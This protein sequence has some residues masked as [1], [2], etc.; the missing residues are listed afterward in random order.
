MWFTLQK[1][2]D[3]NLTWAFQQP[4]YHTH[5]PIRSVLISEILILHNEQNY[6]CITQ[7]LYTL[8]IFQSPKLIQMG[9]KDYEKFY[10]IK[11]CITNK[12]EQTNTM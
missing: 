12:T 1:T 4:I 9:L 7:H 5:I 8:K 6:L 11:R 3:K 10:I 2:A